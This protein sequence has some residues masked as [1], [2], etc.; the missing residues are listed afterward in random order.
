M[1]ILLSF[2]LGAHCVQLQQVTFFTKALIIP[3]Y[4]SSSLSSQAEKVVNKH[5]MKTEKH[6][7]IEIPDFF[8][9]EL[10]KTETK[11]K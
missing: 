4:G 1:D 10:V 8:S 5:L 3:P 7:A 2:Y 6:F 11:L 9:Q